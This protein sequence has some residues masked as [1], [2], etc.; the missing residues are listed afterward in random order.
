MAA[1]VA[2]PK[3]GEIGDRRCLRMD[4]LKSPVEAVRVE[5]DPGPSMGSW[6]AWDYR[7]GDP[8]I[9]R[10]VVQGADREQPQFLSLPE[11]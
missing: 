4:R 1:S 10:G 8:T 5:P 2:P 6:M 3:A 9:G 7:R 11:S